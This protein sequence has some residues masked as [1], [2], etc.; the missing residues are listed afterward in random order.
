MLTRLLTHN[1]RKLANLLKNNAKHSHFP[2]K[3]VTEYSETKMKDCDRLT[4]LVYPTNYDL[5]LKPDLKTGVFEGT[6]KIN[7]TVKADQKKIALHSKF[8][9]IKGLTLNRGDEAIS[10]LKYSREKQSQQLVVHFE[11]VLN[12]G[13]YQMNIEFS[14]DLTRKIVGFYLSHLKDNRYML[15]NYLFSRIHYTNQL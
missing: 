3:L 1:L 8:L 7:I 11:N 14:G 10:I 15:T 13:N 4:P 5:V 6:V 2:S 9:K 12:S